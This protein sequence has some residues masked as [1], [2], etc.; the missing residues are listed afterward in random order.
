MRKRIDPAVELAAEAIQSQPWDLSH[1]WKVLT[2][3]A[4][5][6]KKECCFRQW[7]DPYPGQVGDRK[8]FICGECRLRGPV[9]RVPN[10]Y[11]GAEET[12]EPYDL[13]FCPLDPSCN[14]DRL[15]PVSCASIFADQVNEFCDW[16]DRTLAPDSNGSISWEKAQ[17]AYWAFSHF[18][19]HLPDWDP[20]GSYDGAFERWEEECARENLPAWGPEGPPSLVPLIERIRK[21]RKEALTGAQRAYDE[22]MV[23]A[24]RAFAQAIAEARRVQG[25]AKAA[26][27]RNQDEEIHRWLSRP[28]EVDQGLMAETARTRAAQRAAQEKSNREYR[29]QHPGISSSRLRPA[30]D[31]ESQ[32]A[33]EGP[34]IDM[35]GLSE[36]RVALIHLEAAIRLPYEQAEA[37][38]HRTYDKAAARAERAYQKAMAAPELTRTQRTR[39]K[40]DWD[41]LIQLAERLT[42]LDRRVEQAIGRFL[43]MDVT[44]NRDA[45]IREK[46][47]VKEELGLP[48]A[49]QPPVPKS[50]PRLSQLAACVRDLSAHGRSAKAIY[51]IVKA[52]APKRGI[53]APHISTIYRWIGPRKR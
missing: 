26:L 23:P 38:A 35:A 45:V 8:S 27:R 1:W 41:T 10:L 53:K 11:T 2:F 22:I 31:P 32:S 48:K 14:G 20:T 3:S 15:K 28:H 44:H 49:P 19:K 9:E 17:E 36:E 18:K 42:G 50:G 37:E 51:A 30:P 7:S 52:K 4:L 33:P 6:V 39:E 12:R 34:P 24:E 43:A 40:K 16:L 46:E 21:E 29:E 25:E 47:R 5:A 13:G